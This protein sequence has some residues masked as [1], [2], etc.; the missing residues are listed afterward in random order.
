MHMRKKRAM[1]RAMKKAMKRKTNKEN[2]SFLDREQSRLGRLFFRE[3]EKYGF[4]KPVEN[5]AAPAAGKGITKANG[6]QRR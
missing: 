6:N 3:I 1:Q 2:D 4:S 5:D